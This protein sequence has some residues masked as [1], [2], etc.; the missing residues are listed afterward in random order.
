ME[1]KEKGR[2]LIVK[3]NLKK[4]SRLASMLV[5]ILKEKQVY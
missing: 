3:A 4:K 1:V 5:R 2:M